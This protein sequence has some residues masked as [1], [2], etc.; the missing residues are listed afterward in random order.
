MS[1]IKRAKELDKRLCNAIESQN[2][3]KEAQRLHQY[4]TNLLELVEPISQ[5]KSRIDLLANNGINIS[6]LDAYNEI[7]IVEGILNSFKS[8]LKS[9]TLT[10]GIR[11]KNLSDS[12]STFTYQLK[13]FQLQQ[14]Q[15]YFDSHFFGGETPEIKKSM[16]PSTPFNLSSLQTYSEIYPNFIRYKIRIPIDEQDFKNLKELSDKLSTIEFQVG[17]DVPESV[18]IF[19]DAINLT[20]AS[21][22]LLNIEVIN[23]LKENNLLNNYVVRIRN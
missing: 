11:W 16:L 15:E 13:E 20:G 6:P 19:F 8:D 3:V 9:N 4:H 10:Q 2:G 14:W 1:L 22:E 5:A 18:K 12:L 21:L 7:E 17:E 23:W